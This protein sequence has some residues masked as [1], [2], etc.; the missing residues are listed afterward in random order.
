M[1]RAQMKPIN[2]TFGICFAAVLLFI[3]FGRPAM[4]RQMGLVPKA[5][6]GAQVATLYCRPVCGGPVAVPKRFDG[7]VGGGLEARL[8]GRCSAEVD[9]IFKPREYQRQSAM[10]FLTPPRFITTTDYTEGHSWDF[11]VMLKVNWGASTRRTPYV[12]GGFVDSRTTG[13]TTRTSA[14][15]SLGISSFQSSQ[16]LTQTGILLG[17]GVAWRLRRVRLSPEGRY[18]EGVRDDL[19]GGTKAARNL[20]FVLGISIVGK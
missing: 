17:G 15:S 10:A 11:P 4:A 13:T 8:R 18:T 2:R 19:P 14:D 20:E 3:G 1:M 7:L 9:A 6:V 16:S 12:L 5:V